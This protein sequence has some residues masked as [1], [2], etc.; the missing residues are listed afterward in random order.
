MGSPSWSVTR[1]AVLDIASITIVSWSV[2]LNYFSVSHSF[3]ILHDLGVQPLAVRSIT[4][5]LFSTAAFAMYPRLEIPSC[6][7]LS[8]RRRHVAISGGPAV[9][10]NKEFR[11]SV[12]SVP[13][14]ILS[15]LL[16]SGKI[17]AGMIPTT[18]TWKAWPRGTLS[19]RMGWGGRRAVILA[20]FLFWGI[21]T[22]PGH[23][24]DPRIWKL[25]KKIQLHPWLAE[26]FGKN[27]KMCFL[28]IISNFNLRSPVSQIFT[29]F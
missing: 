7:V 25:A 28:I 16:D 12:M 27:R 24:E 11:S 23:T 5:C 21:T 20:F 17:S 18:R 4:M 10:S 14:W 3:S 19:H 1:K 8:G 6:V 9:Q 29:I 15:S 13:T 26:I 2:N 22:H